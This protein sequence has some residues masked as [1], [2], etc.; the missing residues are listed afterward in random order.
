MPPV[1]SAKMPEAKHVFSMSCKVTAV[2]GG[3]VCADA[4]RVGTCGFACDFGIMH[5]NEVL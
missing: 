1:A 2:N 3:L 5:F 4:L